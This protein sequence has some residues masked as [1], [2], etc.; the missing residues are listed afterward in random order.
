M[1]IPSLDKPALSRPNLMAVGFWP[2]GFV[3][4]Y[5]SSS[6]GN[7]D[8]TTVVVV[9]DNRVESPG[10]D[11]SAG[12]TIEVDTTGQTISA[13][14][15]QADEKTIYYTIPAV[16]I[17]QAVTFAYDAGTGDIRGKDGGADVESVTTQTVTNLIGSGFWFDS[18]EYSAYTAEA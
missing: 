8:E 16:D 10:A 6:I 15:L 5:S 4:A 7:V 18:A 3:P 11:F 1:Q 9:F 14:V 2:V 13:A 17:E 12:V